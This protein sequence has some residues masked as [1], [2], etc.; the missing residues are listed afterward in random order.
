[1][2]NMGFRS[3][4]RALWSFPVLFAA[5]LLSACP[6]F[7]APVREYLEDWTN[8]AAIVRAEYPEAFP[9]DSSGVVSLPSG[10]DREVRLILRN[11]QD[12]DLRPTI[13][14][15]NGETWYNGTDYSFT[16]SQ[17]RRSLTLA[18]S[19]AFLQT[20]DP[21][22]DISSSILLIDDGTGRSFDPYVLP[23]RCNSAPPPILGSCV[24]MNG[25]SQVVC[26]SLDLSDSVHGDIAAIEVNGSRHEVGVN[27]ATNRLILDE[28]SDF[29]DPSS[30]PLASVPGTSTAFAP[31]AGAQAV[32]VD[33]RLPIISENDVF[34][35]RVIDS[36][37]LSS[38][39]TTS[40]RG[41]K[42]GSPSFRDLAGAIVPEG[43]NLLPGP[44]GMTSA[45]MISAPTVAGSESGLTA[46][47]LSWELRRQ[48]GGGVIDSGAA[49]DGASL[50]L[51]NG[52]YALTAYARKNGYIDS[53]PV[54]LRFTVSST[55]FYVDSLVDFDADAPGTLAR[56]MKYLSYAIAK[57]TND[58]LH[59]RV[60][61]TGVHTGGP[62]DGVLSLT[63]RGCDIDFIGYGTQAVVD[64][65]RS[66][67]VV[68]ISTGNTAA[69]TVTFSGLTIR[70]GFNDSG[71]PGAG[72]HF[73]AP[74]GNLVIEDCVIIGNATT[75]TGGG[76]Y[77]SSPGGDLRITATTEITG[78]SANAGGGVSFSSER[79]A[80]S[81]SDSVISGNSASGFGGGLY[82]YKSAGTE[83]AVYDLRSVD[84]YGNAADGSGGTEGGAIMLNATGANCTMNLVDCEIGGETIESG[85]TAMRFGGGLSLRGGT[86][87]MTNCGVQ[88]NVAFQSTSAGSG[89]GGGLFADG[90][91]VTLTD[92][93]FSGN[94]ANSPKAA[95]SGA[96]G[97]GGAMAF[98]SG[99]LRVE[100]RSVIR[101][102]YAIAGG[103][104]GPTERGY[105]GGIYAYFSSVLLRD[106]SSVRENGTND[107]ATASPAMIGGGVFFEGNT[108]HL[109]RIQDS[110]SVSENTAE[111]AGGGVYMMSGRMELAAGSIRA[112]AVS[113][114]AGQ[115]GG[116]LLG[117]T[118]YLTM[119]GG[120]VSD[121][122]SLGEGSGIMIFEDP[123]LSPA[124]Q[125]FSLGGAVDFANNSIWIPQLTIGLDTVYIPITLLSGISSAARIR[126]RA[127]SIIITSPM[128]APEGMVPGNNDFFD[129]TA[130][131]LSCYIDSSGY[132][133]LR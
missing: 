10:A 35:I 58:T 116:I 66:K 122:V 18:F 123:S 108:D 118:A 7:H 111:S 107:S 48:S 82:L 90:A 131:G 17:D 55:V 87:T 99:S 50:T 53:D 25:N 76:V 73:I 128:L 61:V 120:S 28:D 106:S 91:S 62:V 13:S 68:F 42:L 63:N 115:G 30:V 96:Q 21:D 45:I 78:N 8:N 57:C 29:L 126:L 40:S 23:L 47:N 41:Q 109:L 3:P 11:P 103:D 69:F 71:L 6:N 49:L 101:G 132:V 60:Y 83:N 15:V 31:T 94:A 37:G 70:D 36:R 125:K 34:M 130:A 88:N 27:A 119:S 100:G 2:T 77:F 56:P 24:M 20:R 92:C 80:L 65:E 110:A 89:Y 112:N 114:S 12:Y 84:F 16:L 64:G 124:Y 22:G 46:V 9:T 117:E 127:Q 51:E 33:T 105:G 129:V 102:N 39:A 72:I 79:G 44:D 86:V 19:E 38:S 67:R 59:Y 93:S 4:S 54:T 121:N 26:F 74:N 14:A 43:G 81:I 95:F 85:N 5:L 104:G 98:Y 75:G 32:Y 1:M 52:S 113:S 133:H 97:F